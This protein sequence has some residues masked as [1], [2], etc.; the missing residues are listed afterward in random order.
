MNRFDE[1][2]HFVVIFFPW[3]RF[4]GARHIN[5]KRV[6]IGDSLQHILLVQS[7]CDDHGSKSVRA[8]CEF[9][10]KALSHTW[11]TTV[12]EECAAAVAAERIDTKSR[13][14]SKSFD[15]FHTLDHRAI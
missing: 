14:N 15:H 5:C 11:G 2:P 7:A 1:S 13:V 6:Q 9:P 10:I 4:D 12:Q 8:I 3:R